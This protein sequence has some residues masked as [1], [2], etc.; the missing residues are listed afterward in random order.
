MHDSDTG[1]AKSFESTKDAKHY[2]GDKVYVTQQSFSDSR[3]T[4]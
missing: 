3:S 2:V 4:Y 1:R